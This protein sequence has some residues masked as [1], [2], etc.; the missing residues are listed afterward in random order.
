MAR[1]RGAVLHN[2]ETIQANVGTGSL[3]DLMRLLATAGF[4]AVLY[5]DSG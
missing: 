4:A 3:V 5:P 1:V 2:V